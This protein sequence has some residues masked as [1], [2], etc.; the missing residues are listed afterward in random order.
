MMDVTATVLNNVREYGDYW[1]LR[2]KIPARYAVRPG[3]FAMIRPSAQW[4]PILRRAMVFYRVERGAHALEAE[5][6]YRVMGRGTRRLAQL[7]SG[8][9]LDV[10]GPLGN[11]FTIGE[12]PP[13]GRDVALVSGGIGIPALYLLA[14]ELRRRGFVPRLFHGDRTSDVER[15]LICVD[16]FYALLGRDH[17]L[18]TTEDG[19]YGQRG[20]VTDLLESALQNRAWRPLALY[21][22]GPEPMM[23]R[24]AQL[25]HQFHIPAELSLEAAMACGFGVCLAC[26][27]RVRRDDRITYVRVCCEGPVFRA[28]DIVWEEPMVDRPSSG[29]AQNGTP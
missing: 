22:C 6:I 5:F 11:G 18:C 10:L 1:R 27:Q 20:V 13:T 29:G 12:P 14:A 21:A 16:D 7:R 8:D 19:S 15:G 25:A 2:V 24:V 17:V 26:V 23:K 4:E 28:E 9:R 3:Q